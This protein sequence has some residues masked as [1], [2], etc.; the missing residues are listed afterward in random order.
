M[1]NDYRRIDVIT[2]DVLRRRWTTEQKLPIIEESFEPG[3]R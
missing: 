1:S 3:D 2:G